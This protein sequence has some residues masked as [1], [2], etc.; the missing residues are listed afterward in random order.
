M[1][2]RAGR[3]TPVFSGWRN[4]SEG[5]AMT[6]SGRG[7]DRGG[8]KAVRQG[9][10]CAAAA[11][12]AMAVSD[13]GCRGQK[14]EIL[15]PL[16]LFSRPLVL[17]LA[18]APPAGAPL[19]NHPRTGATAP[20]R[21]IGGS[22]YLCAGTGSDPVK[23]GSL[24]STSPTTIKPAAASSTPPSTSTRTATTSPLSRLARAAC[25]FPATTRPPGAIRPVYDRGGLRRDTRAGHRLGSAQARHHPSRPQC[26]A[27][28]P[29]L[30]EAGC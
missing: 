11:P 15:A 9:M 2:L 28:L 23:S 26:G 30:A 6:C 12:P 16:A 3:G 4:L 18:S 7:R 24:R 10:K 17:L 21:A 29:V 14:I 22:A 25:S 5:N 19:L 20:N 8:W 27:Q 1:R 13:R